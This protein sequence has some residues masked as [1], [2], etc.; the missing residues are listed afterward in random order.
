MAGGGADEVTTARVATSDVG[1]MAGSSR[2]V[3]T[4]GVASMV[5]GSGVDSVAI[6]AGVAE[7][8]AMILRVSISAIICAF[9][10]GSASIRAKSIPRDEPTAAS[11][12]EVLVFAL[13]AICEFW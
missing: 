7:A 4:A 1:V 9:R 8:E 13:E 3:E 11:A 12:D 6:E 5:A 10:A 2:V